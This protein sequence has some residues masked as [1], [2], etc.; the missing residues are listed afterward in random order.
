LVETEVSTYLTGTRIV[1]DFFCKLG[2]VFT[3]YEPLVD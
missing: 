2:K 1:R 3:G